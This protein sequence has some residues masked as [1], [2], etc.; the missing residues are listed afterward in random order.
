L[1]ADAEV[2]AA[3]ATR[4]EARVKC[5]FKIF[6]FVVLSMDVR[7]NRSSKAGLKGQR[8]CGNIEGRA[9]TCSD[10]NNERGGEDVYDPAM[11]LWKHIANG[12]QNKIE[13][14]KEI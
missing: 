13:K 3:M 8:S 7:W 6:F 14:E 10:H 2:A 4:V 12:K 11:P 5:I 9:R 1:A